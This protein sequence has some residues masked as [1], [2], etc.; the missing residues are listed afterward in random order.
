MVIQENKPKIIL[1]LFVLDLNRP[2]FLNN[3]HPSAEIIRAG[4]NFPELIQAPEFI[5]SELFDCSSFDP[6][7]M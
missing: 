4:S 5:P 7:K 1:N 3:I 6:S 2:F